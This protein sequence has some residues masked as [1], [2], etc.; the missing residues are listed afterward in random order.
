MTRAGP[1]ATRSG[2]TMPHPRRAG[3]TAADAGSPRQDPGLSAAGPR[4]GGEQGAVAG[5]AEEAIRGE[6][7]DAGDAR[8]E[9]GQGQATRSEGPMI[10]LAAAIAACLLVVADAAPAAGP[11]RPN[12]VF[13]LA[14]DLG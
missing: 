10:R 5:M 3:A 11:P 4:G 13:I 8:E 7:R 1:I 12:V 14:D 6:A 2:G 9:E